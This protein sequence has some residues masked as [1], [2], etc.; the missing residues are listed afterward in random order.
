MRKNHIGIQA[1]P[2][3]AITAFA[4]DRF[5]ARR[6]PSRTSGSLWGYDEELKRIDD[7]LRGLES[8]LTACRDELRIARA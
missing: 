6:M 5:G 8:A 3:S 4:A 2:R 7:Q 1:A